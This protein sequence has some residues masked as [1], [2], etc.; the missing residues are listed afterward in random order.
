[1]L[2]PM[3]LGLCPVSILLFF[4]SICAANPSLS[5]PGFPS[6]VRALG[7]GGSGQHCMQRSCMWAMRV[8]TWHVAHA[9]QLAH[10]KAADTLISFSPLMSVP[11]SN[12]C[13]SGSLCTHLG[14]CPVQGIGLARSKSKVTKSTEGFEYM[15]AR[16]LARISPL[17]VGKARSADLM[18]RICLGFFV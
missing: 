15:L 16:R 4:H 2:F 14:L 5:R 3:Y 11:G 6:L 12:S 8:L 1:M 10:W 17:Y 9:S 13:L 7:A 18:L